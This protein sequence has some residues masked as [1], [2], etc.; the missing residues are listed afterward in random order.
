MH[1]HHQARTA[2]QHSAAFLTSVHAATTRGAQAA[3]ATA[4][5]VQQ[6]LGEGT[7]MV[8]GACGTVAA[9]LRAGGVRVL[10]NSDVVGGGCVCVCWVVVWM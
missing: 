10:A 5:A 9:A 8:G 2:S 1:L 6:Q 4:S 7:A 3:T